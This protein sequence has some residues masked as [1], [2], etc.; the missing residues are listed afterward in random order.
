MQAFDDCLVL[1]IMCCRK[2]LPLALLRALIVSLSLLDFM[3]LKE[4]LSSKMLERIAD[5]CG[6]NRT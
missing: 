3:T 5:S 2:W 4:S 1:L 6:I